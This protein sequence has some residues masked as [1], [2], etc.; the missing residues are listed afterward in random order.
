MRF[1]KDFTPYPHFIVYDF[2]AILAPLNKHPTDD[3]T[4]LSRHIPISAAVH[5][6][7]SKEPVYL[8]D[9]NP[10]RFIKWIIEVLTGKLEAIAADALRQRP[11]PSD[12]QKLPAEEQKQW[13]QWDNQVPVIGFNN[14]K[15]DLNIVK[16]YFEK[17][18]SYNKED[19]CN[20]D[21]F[22]AM[23][24]NDYMLLTTFKFKFLDVKNYTGTCLSYNA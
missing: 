1:E 11:Y 16:A 6:A 20:E 3:L 23:K 7:L 22:A 24:E 17:K 13:R 15:Y 21:V 14:G 12:F 18:I 9:K 4:Y 10:K 5:D 8:V 19:E 2:E